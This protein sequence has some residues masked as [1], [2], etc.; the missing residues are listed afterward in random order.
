MGTRSTVGLMLESAIG[1]ECTNTIRSMERRCPGA[2][3]PEVRRMV[4]Q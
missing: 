1:R 3:I 4:P 2:I